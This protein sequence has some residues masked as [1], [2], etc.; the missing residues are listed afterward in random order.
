MEEFAFTFFENATATVNGNISDERETAL[1]LEPSKVI[2]VISAKTYIVL[3]ALFSYANVIVGTLGIVNNL[4]VIITYGKIGFSDTINISYIALAISDLGAV[5]TRLWGALCFVFAVTD[6]DLPFN[7]GELAILSSFWPAQGFEKITAFITAFIALERCLCVQFPLH[8]KRMVTKKRTVFILVFAYVFGLGPQNLSYFVFNIQSIFNPEQNK[9]IIRLVKLPGVARSITLR[10]LFA[11]YGTFL[12]FTAMFTVWICTIF[13]AI[14]L[15]KIATIRD[16]SLGQ[17]ST[18]HDRKKKQH[19]IKTVFLLATT[20]LAFSTPTAGTLL[21]PHF[22]PEFETT[23]ALAR[24]ATV[25][26]LLSGLMSQFNSS[27]NLY[28]YVY[29]GSKF[30]ETFLALFKKTVPSTKG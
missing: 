10:V 11:Y 20:Y 1:H 5:S 14:T 8:V 22:E 17:V 26:H 29:M 28:I 24:I 6:T 4:F 23:K 27:T 25:S 9:T 12:H 13:L 3:V 15:R 16:K 2:A 21:V 18:K 19:V 30:R 7:P